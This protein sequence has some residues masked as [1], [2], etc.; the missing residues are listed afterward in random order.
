MTDELAEMVG[1]L[2]GIAWRYDLP[3][4]VAEDAIQEALIAAWKILE[5]GRSPALA[6]SAA[7]QAI[8]DVKRGRS[9]TGTKRKPGV[10]GVDVH[11]RYGTPLVVVLPGGGE[12][13]VA[14]PPDLRAVK[15]LEAAETGALDA[16]RAL[17]PEHRRLVYLLFWEGL[18][19][20]EAGKEL[21]ISSSTAS[22]R[23]QTKIRPVLREALG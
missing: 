8:L 18:T 3:D 4:T 14:D 23:W 11:E 15:A 10:N 1:P 12:T 19:F 5:S 22:A 2:R 17:P 21:G 7:R 20:A 13:L 9:M 6:W 16:V